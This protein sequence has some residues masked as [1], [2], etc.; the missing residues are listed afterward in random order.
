MAAMPI[1]R[2]GI[3]AIVLAL[4]FGAGLAVR[5]ADYGYVQY[6]E[7]DFAHAESLL[8]ERAKNGDPWAAFITGGMV[9]A[10]RASMEDHCEVRRFWRQAGDEG[11]AVA[12]SAY[13]VFTTE[14]QPDADTCGW[15]RDSLD[16]LLGEQPQYAAEMRGFIEREPICGGSRPEAALEWF[17][18]AELTGAANAGDSVDALLEASGRS[19]DDVRSRAEALLPAAPRTPDWQA[20][21]AAEPP[22]RNCPGD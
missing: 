14:I 6:V 7:G 3:A 13:V 10:R 17:M 1:L 18:A 22:V 19:R 4:A 11:I 5:Q 15:A 12:R 16:L 21:V 9:A 2:P 20:I 8:R